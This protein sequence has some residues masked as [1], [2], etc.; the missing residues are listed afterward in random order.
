MPRDRATPVAWVESP[1]QMIGA[2]EWARARGT[3]VDLAGRLTTQVEATAAELTARG[4]L[5]ARQA[6]FYG[7]PWAMLRGSDHWLVGDGFS[8]QFRL[9]AA[10]LRPRT[11]TFL[12]DG[13]QAVSFADALTGARAFSRP[14]ASERGLARRVAPLTMDLIRLRAAAGRVS[15]FTAF[16]MGR[17]RTQALGDLGARVEEHDFAWVRGTRAARPLPGGRVLLGSAR[18]VDGLLP[19]EDYL[20]WIR[21][22]ASAGGA[23]YVPHRRESR[24]LIA[25]VAAVP[26]IRVA[27]PGLP[28]ELVLAGDPTPREI[29]TLPSSAATTLRR[30]LRASECVV[31][32]RGAD[33][34]VAEARG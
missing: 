8:G 7:I 29:V 26:R 15:I 3:R 17:A 1:L 18:V 4:A 5:F 2:A 34:R 27:E 11:L 31:V 32:E 30:V 14:G 28:I 20:A 21:A 6:G 13:L 24:E 12:D 22:E 33:A 25:A 10:V 19:R 23:V 9:A 16:E